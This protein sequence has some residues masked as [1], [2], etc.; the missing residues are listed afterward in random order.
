MAAIRPTLGPLPR[1][2]AV[3]RPDRALTPELLDDGAII[4]RRILAL[5]NP[6]EDVGAMHLRGFLWRI[7]E[8]AG[9]GTATA[10]TLF[11][12]LLANG[13]RMLVAGVDAQQLRPQLEAVGELVRGDLRAQARHRDDRAHHIDLARAISHDDELAELLGDIFDVSGEFGTIAVL[14]SNRRDSWREFVQGSYWE[15]GAR[16]NVHLG[17]QIRLRSDLLEPALLLSNLAIDDPADLLPALEA[18]LASNARGLVVI[19]D[20]ISE[21]AVALLMANSRPNFPIVAVKPPGFG[22]AGRRAALDDLATLTGG[23]VFWSEAGDRLDR[24][25][26]ADLGRAR[27]AWA[28]MQHVGIV[29]GQG[30]ALAIRRRVEELERRY[31]DAVDNEERDKIQA[32]LGSYH[33]VAATL[34]VGGDSDLGS[35]NRQETAKRA[36]A[37]LRRA[38]RDGS[39]PGGGAALLRCQAALRDRLASA[40]DE[41]ERAALRIVADALDAPLRAILTNCGHEPAPVLARLNGAGDGMGFDARSGVIVDARAAGIV[42]PL[43]VVTAATVGAIRSVALAL[44]IDAIVHTRSTEISVDPE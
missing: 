17:D 30:D 34:W 36:I 16:S 38:L 32:R 43:A 40:C 2:V 28:T 23:R 25:Q 15:G 5:P 10:A 35:K 27:I 21:R 12:A 33:G 8:R 24:L 37:V 4:A 9:D 29:A 41:T 31:D 11:G 3:Q 26:P 19:S 6:A 22:E 44:T 42:D 13:R 7:H 14:P 39:V 1:A 18:A 20:S